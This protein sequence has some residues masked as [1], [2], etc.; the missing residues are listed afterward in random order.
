MGTKLPP[1]SQPGLRQS[2]PTSETSPD[3]PVLIKVPCSHSPVSSYPTC[4][5]FAVF[6]ASSHHICLLVLAILTY[7]PLQFAY[8]S[9]PRLSADSSTTLLQKH[10]HE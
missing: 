2:V 8:C 4:F 5:S 1:S 6:P 10:L 3:H 9:G 7:K